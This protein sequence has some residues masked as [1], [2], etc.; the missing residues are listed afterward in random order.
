MDFLVI[1]LH[2]NND[3]IIES[4]NCGIFRHGLDINFNQLNPHLSKEEC[5]KQTEFGCGKPFQIILKD[6][7]YIAIVC[8]YI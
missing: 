6:E 2:C 7:Q 1:C 3:V 5:D 4:I 8:D